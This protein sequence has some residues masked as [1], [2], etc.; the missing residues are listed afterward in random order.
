LQRG[1]F[2]SVGMLLV[3]YILDKVPAGPGTR[4]APKRK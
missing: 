3:I 4:K 1:I 2:L